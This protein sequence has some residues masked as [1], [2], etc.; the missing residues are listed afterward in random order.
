MTSL[1]FSIFALIGVIFI[2]IGG[3]WLGSNLKFQEEA[4]SVS[5]EIVEIDTYRD[6]DG[7]RHHNVYVTY[8]HDG[9]TYENVRLGEYSSS[10]YEGKEIEILCDP[11]NP[12]RIK[13]GLGIY[14]GGAIFGFMGLT[15]VLIGIIPLLV[16]LNGKKKM[17]KLM[18]N[19]QV[20]HAVVDEISWNT[21]IRVNGQN[22]Y[23][24]YCSYKD[25]YKDVIYRFKSTNLWTDPNLVFT[26]G[27]Y[28]DVYVDVNDYSNYY[29]NAEQVI[30][31]KVVDYT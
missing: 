18:A 16:S 25:E 4:V 6:S 7:D 22:P 10:M 30:E 28:I 8:D 9:I 13:T 14:M 31:Q 21:N 11:Q 2:L 15:F 24:I 27:S 5:A 12:G 19:G 20:L 23:V 26:P 17:R 3:I 1:L 29:V